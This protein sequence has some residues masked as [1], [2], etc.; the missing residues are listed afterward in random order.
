ML[1]EPCYTSALQRIKNSTNAPQLQ[2]CTF[3]ADQMACNATQV[4]VAISYAHQ[5]ALTF[6]TDVVQ[7]P[8]ANL[9]LLLI[10]KLSLL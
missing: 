10:Y 7:A 6:I 9:V 4:P 1:T 5:K 8:F 3:I 2:A